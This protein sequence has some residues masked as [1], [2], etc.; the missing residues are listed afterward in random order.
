MLQQAPQNIW[1]GRTAREL[2]DR[3]LA[4]LAV[5]G[6]LL[7]ATRNT[8][9]VKALGQRTVVSQVVQRRQQL[10]ARQIAR[11]A[12]DHKC[13]GGDRQTLQSCRERV[14]QRISQGMGCGIGVRIA[15]LDI[16]WLTLARRR[17]PSPLRRLLDCV[18]AE[19]VA[20]RRQHSV[21]EVAVPA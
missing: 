20:Q 11:G 9:E 10:A 18:T 16:S 3:L 21:S 19:L 2:A 4:L 15:P 13:R 6:V 14:L 7:I 1:I 5:I 17:S 8:D 12:E